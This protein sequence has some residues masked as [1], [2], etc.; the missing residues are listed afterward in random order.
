MS[1]AILKVGDVVQWRGFFGA[2][3]PLYAKIK[4]IQLC[5]SERMKFGIEV[6]EAFWKEK[7]RLCVTLT[8]GSWAYGHQL[9]PI[10]VNQNV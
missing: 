8:N 9:S 10:K 6:G 2:A 7:R 4:S 3:E 5:E 1:E